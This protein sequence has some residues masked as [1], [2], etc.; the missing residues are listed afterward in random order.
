MRDISPESPE[1]RLQH[2]GAHPHRRGLLGHLGPG[3]RP[4]EFARRVVVGVYN[5]GF[6]HAGNLAYLT[7]LALFP[8]F[9]IIAAVAQFYGGAE[10]T[11]SAIHA[12]GAA[13]P[14][15]VR[16]LVEDTAAQVV[17]LRTG[18]LLWL[19]AAIGVWT[20]GSY[21]ETIREILR[22]AYGTDYAR[23]FWQY[24]L[25]GVIIIFAAVA[26]LMFAFSAQILLTTAE[27]VIARFFPAAGTLADRIGDTRFIPV[28]ATLIANYLLFWTLAPTKYR[29]W[30]Y[31]KWPG[32]LFATLWW[33]V[34][35]TQLPRAIGLFGGY[36]LTYGGLAGVMV[37]LLFFWLVGYGLVIGAHINAALANP[38][39]TGLKDH[40]VLDELTEA[41]W[42]DT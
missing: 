34:A 22:R 7:L 2:P 42:L 16:Q 6:T 26:L 8:F 11:A 5:E 18:P 4:F 15:A 14:P 40:P 31:P 28:V 9:I 24:R 17:S 35:L 37:A 1:A 39:R 13:L 3:S 20:V 32:A 23:P 21:I 36:T 38:E 10:G 33:Y 29:S 25:I 41:R 19:G 12:V 27:E 30:T